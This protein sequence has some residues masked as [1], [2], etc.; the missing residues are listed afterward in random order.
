MLLQL[1]GIVEWVV[2]RVVLHRRC[3]PELQ[4]RVVQGF[5][6]VFTSVAVL[7]LGGKVGHAGQGIDFV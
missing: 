1:D 2:V 6:L 7:G 3:T 5:S 4:R